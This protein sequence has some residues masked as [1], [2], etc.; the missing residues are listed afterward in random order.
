MERGPEDGWMPF[1]GSHYLLA[2]SEKKE[3]GSALPCLNLFRGGG[4]GMYK[5]LESY[6]G[7]NLLIINKSGE[8]EAEEDDEGS[9]LRDS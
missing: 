8:G 6:V 1:L 7:N 2:Q 5:V 9:C 4:M 3:V